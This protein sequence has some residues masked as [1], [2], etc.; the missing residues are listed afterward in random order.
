MSAFTPAEITYLQSQPLG[1]LATVEPDGQP[2]MVPVSFRYNPDQ[3]TIDIGGHG[4]TNRKKFRDVR[5]TPRVAFVV[6]DHS[7]AV[8]L[9]TE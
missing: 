3:D 6:D 9:P 4:F 8:I 1:H 7:R 2:H 5:H